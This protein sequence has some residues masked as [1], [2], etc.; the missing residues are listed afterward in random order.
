MNEFDQFRMVRDLIWQI[1]IQVCCFESVFHIP[2]WFDCSES[3]TYWWGW[4]FYWKKYHMTSRS[5]ITSLLLLVIFYNFFI[6]FSC[7]Q[8]FFFIWQVFFVFCNVNISVRFGFGWWKFFEI[9]SW[10]CCCGYHKRLFQ[11]IIFLVW[12]NLITWHGCWWLCW[13]ISGR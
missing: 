10:R 7:F 1:W 11:F 9:Q 12:R 2:V 13:Q 8:N 5:N 3:Y 4:S 6:V